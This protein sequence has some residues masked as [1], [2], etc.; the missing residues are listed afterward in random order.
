LDIDASSMAVHASIALGLNFSF[1]S[2]FRKDVRRW[3][4]STV[5]P[6]GKS[7]HFLMAF[8]FRHAKFKLNPDS[9]SLALESYI[10]GGFDDLAVI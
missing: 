2:R 10:G 4:G 5:H 6:L 1:G 7:N 3:F 8:S 9:I